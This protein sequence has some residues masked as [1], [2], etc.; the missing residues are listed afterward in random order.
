MNTGGAPYHDY[1]P[2]E[3]GEVTIAATASLSGTIHIGRL[4]GG[5]ALLMPAAWTEAVLTF[6]G[7]VDGETFGNV[8]DQEGEV[9]YQAAANAFIELDPAQFK[10]CRYLRVRSGTAGSA[11]TQDAARAIK[12]VTRAV[13]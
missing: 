8:F 10:C 7:S 9:E 11:V 12:V 3:L 13:S 4:S 1:E 5:V 6:Q 2:A